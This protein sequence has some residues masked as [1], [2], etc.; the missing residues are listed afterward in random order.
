MLNRFSI[1]LSLLLV[2]FYSLADKPQQ[3]PVS[4]FN[5]MPMVDQPSISPDGKNIAV[6]TNRNDQTQVAITP[7]ENPANMTTI[8][9]LGSEEY[10]IESIHWA[11]NE[12]ILVTVTQPFKV[13]T[14]RVRARHIFSVSIDGKSRFEFANKKKRT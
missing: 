5:Q 12:R 13:G 4:S 14:Y 2:S 11:N 3:I 6:I 10:R 8:V 7:F 9:G 1:V